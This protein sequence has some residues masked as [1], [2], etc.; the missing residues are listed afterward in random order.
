MP[1][2][3]QGAVFRFGHTMVRP[4]YR[5]NFTGQPAGKP[6]APQFFGFIFDPALGRDNV[7]IATT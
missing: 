4:S 7:E 3:F 5:A 2:E 6:N 1:V